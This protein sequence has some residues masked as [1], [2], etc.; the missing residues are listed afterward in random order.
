MNSNSD[1]IKAYN[2]ALD[3]ISYREHFSQELEAKLCKRGF[4]KSVVS[5]VIREFI[6]KSYLDDLRAA[7]LYISEK[8]YKYGKARLSAMLYDR[9]LQSSDVEIILDEIELS[10]REKLKNIIDGK[11]DEL[12]FIPPYSEKEIAKLARFADSRGFGAG[13]IYE[14]VYE[15]RGKR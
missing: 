7:R 1:Y 15:L 10:D 11:I 9:G 5:D 8:Q 12:G 2:K 4:D 13:L 6:A 3:I 14:V